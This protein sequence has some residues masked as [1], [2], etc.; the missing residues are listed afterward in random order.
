MSHNPVINADEKSDT[1]IVP[2]KLANKDRPMGCSAE[3]MEGRGVT[4]GNADKPPA[5]RTQSRDYDAS[6][7][8]EDIRKLAR[9]DKNVQFTALL[10]HVTP[11]LLRESFYAL[12]RDAAVGVDGVTWRDYEQDLTERLNRLH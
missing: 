5:C 2:R 11:Q 7:A 10:H 1:S 9:K 6:M 8:L 3:R 12:R 4:K